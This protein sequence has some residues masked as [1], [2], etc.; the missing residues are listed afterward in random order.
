M[1]KFYY[2]DATL[3]FF[4]AP[5]LS[6]MG[7]N[8]N[9]EGEE[10]ILHRFNIRYLI[11]KVRN[12]LR[13]IAKSK[14]TKKGE[15][16]K[17]IYFFVDT[18]NDDLE[19]HIRKLKEKNIIKD[20]SLEYIAV[21]IKN[22]KCTIGIFRVIV[23]EYLVITV[24]NLGGIKKERKGEEYSIEGLI[25]NCLLK[26]DLLKKLFECFHGKGK[27]IIDIRNKFYEHVGIKYL[28]ILMDTLD[29]GLKPVLL[30][31]ID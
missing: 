25:E 2:E 30:R 12:S 7:Y 27:S 29:K 28:T 26:D 14:H 15:I 17:K 8:V 4:L 24:F 3:K 16:P 9:I 20:Y 1:V 23:D 11:G 6:S 21:D 18:K 31:Y 19:N 22:D 10:D 5:I 13:Y